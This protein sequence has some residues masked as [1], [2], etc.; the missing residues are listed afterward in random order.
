MVIFFD[1]QVISDPDGPDAA[2]AKVMPFLQ[3]TASGTSIT[4]TVSYVDRSRQID[5]DG[6][7]KMNPC[8]DLC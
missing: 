1:P 5:D 8:S 2:F 6:L 3:A 7:L 4:L